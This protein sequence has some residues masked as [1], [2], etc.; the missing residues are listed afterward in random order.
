[1]IFDLFVFVSIVVYSVILAKYLQ[2]KRP[3]WKY[4]LNNICIYL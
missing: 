1:M 2:N 3:F 4:N